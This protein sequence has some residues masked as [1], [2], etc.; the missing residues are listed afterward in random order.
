MWTGKDNNSV[1]FN[2]HHHFTFIHAIEELIEVFSFAVIMMLLPG[3]TIFAS[4]HN[5]L[6]LFPSHGPKMRDLHNHRAVKKHC[7]PLSVEL[8]RLKKARACE[9]QMLMMTLVNGNDVHSWNIS[10]KE[11]HLANASDINTGKGHWFPLWP[12]EERCRDDF[13]DVLV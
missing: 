13:N 7:R 8:H 2:H 5:E 3:L 10:A 12:Q 1:V 11:G 9:T 6:S 4:E